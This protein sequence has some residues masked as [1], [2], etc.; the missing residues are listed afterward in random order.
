ML[1]GATFFL[2][3]AIATLPVSSGVIGLLTT[4]GGYIFSNSI[5]KLI[6]NVTVDQLA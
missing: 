3:A 4:E 5:N 2:I 1:T 6:D